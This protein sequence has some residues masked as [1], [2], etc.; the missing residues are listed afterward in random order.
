MSSVTRE[1]DTVCQCNMSVKG[2]EETMR[3]GSRSPNVRLDNAL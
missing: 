2:Q 1:A 3:S